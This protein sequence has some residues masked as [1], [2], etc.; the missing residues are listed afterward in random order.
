MTGAGRAGDPPPP[1]P[2]L[3]AQRPPAP[4][5]LP[6]SQF[7]THLRLT[8]GDWR[9][10][11]AREGNHPRRLPGADPPPPAPT[12]L[13][14]GEAAQQASRERSPGSRP[15]RETMEPTGWCVPLAPG[16]QPPA[17]PPPH[18][19]DRDPARGTRQAAALLHG[20]LPPNDPDARE[21]RGPEGWLPLFPVP[22]APPWQP[23]PALGLSRCRAARPASQKPRLSPRS[24]PASPGQLRPPIP[25]A[26]AGARRP[27][28]RFS[29]GPLSVCTLSS[30]PPVGTRVCERR[31]PR[32]PSARGLPTRRPAARARSSTTASEQ[33]AEPPS[34][35]STPFSS[36]LNSGRAAPQAKSWDSILT[37]W[38][39]SSQGIRAAGKRPWAPSESTSRHSCCC[40]GSHCISHPAA[41]A[42][43][44]VPGRACCV[45]P[46]PT[47][48][49]GS[50]EGRQ[51]SKQ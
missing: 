13:S 18:H 7:R 26:R 42:S 30:A 4:A 10:A 29:P 19:G 32:G 28:C 40:P 45:Q 2:A 5:L 44:L 41:P 31:H 38:L 20:A 14:P 50:L 12:A 33:T 36:R 39:S 3:A 48:Q 16:P 8:W 27:S 17:A 51:W 22:P 46:L 23:L 25:N 6:K 37:S 15:D 1:P 24:L 11:E 35:P 49:P 21:T 43:H 34:G 9:S 47:R